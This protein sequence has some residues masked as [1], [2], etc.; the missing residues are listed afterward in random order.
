[1]LKTR[2]EALSRCVDGMK[3]AL[4]SD[5]GLE[6]FEASRDVPAETVQLLLQK[7]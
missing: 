6:R 3:L 7:S 2:L 4:Q 1:M 5:V